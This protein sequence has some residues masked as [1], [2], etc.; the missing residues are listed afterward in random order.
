[1]IRDSLA[2]LPVG[3]E[4]VGVRA[5]ANALGRDFTMR[6]QMPDGSLLRIDRW[7]ANWPDTYYFALP[8]R[9]P[10]GTAIQVEIAY[11]NSADNPRN[12][13]TPP[14][15]IGWGRMS[16]GELG[17]MTLLIASPSTEDAKALDDA[18]AQHLKDLL[19][20]K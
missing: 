2:V 8:M 13:F 5:Y 20:R 1:M 6:A 9:L 3:V 15:R 18:E 16:V 12:L 11:D 10:A 19:L 14:R 17:G 7:D 4:V